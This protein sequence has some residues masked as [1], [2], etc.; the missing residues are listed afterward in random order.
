M[1][2]Y[3]CNSKEDKILEITSDLDA[4][5]IMLMLSITTYL[6][7][8]GRISVQNHRFGNIST[9]TLLQLGYIRLDNYKKDPAN[10]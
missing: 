6:E 5:Y 8:T 2:T 1:S 10:N 4:S 7:I 3:S 9:K